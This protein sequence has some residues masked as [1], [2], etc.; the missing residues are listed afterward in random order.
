MTLTVTSGSTSI[1][2]TGM[3]A[4]NGLEI[5]RQDIC[6]T[7]TT[8]DGKTHRGRIATK[9]VI[10]VTV[11]PRTY[12]DYCTLATLLENE[13]VTVTYTDPVLSNRNA[14]MY[15]EERSAALLVRYAAGTEYWHKIEFTLREA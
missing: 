5:T 15:V 7:I 6:S 13:Y 11:I 12:V 3:I 2:L 8:M 1:D 14:T 10:S 4:Q 9:A